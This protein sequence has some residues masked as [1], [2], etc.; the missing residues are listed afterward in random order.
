[1]WKLVKILIIIAVLAIAWWLISP[2]FIN[3]EVNEDLDPRVESALD[4]VLQKTGEGL[5]KAGEAIG[6]T[7]TKDIQDKIAEMKDRSSDEETNLEDQITD[8][9]MME[10]FV[11]EMSEAE[12]HETQET[13]P[14]ED[15]SLSLVASGQFA[16][17][18]HEGSGDVRIFST[19]ENGETIVRFENL[20]VL[21]GPDLRVL[22]SKNTDI[23]S[24]NNLGEY[25]EL[26][27]L[28]GNKGN[29]NYAVPA[30]VDIS[31]YKSVVIYCKPFHVVFNSANVNTN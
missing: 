12:D 27:A 20:D 3:K 22:I 4:T 7:T 28:K 13:M 24:S 21:N 29:Q 26:G 5:Q 16:S 31:E 18:A 8:D 25:V 17:V 15:A 2:L 6:D 11:E 10:K 19:G 9:A 1:M 23:R 14:K 30:N